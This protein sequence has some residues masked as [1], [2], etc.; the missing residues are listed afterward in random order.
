MSR[1]SILHIV[2]LL[3]ITLSARAQETVT[4]LSGNHLLT[5]KTNL[6]PASVKGV[7][8]TLEL[9]F[10]DD[11]TNPGAYP[12][13]TLWSDKYVFI[14][15][16]F[17]VDQLT[18]GV[19][20]FDL[21]DHTGR[22][23]DDA[24]TW[25]FKA[26]MLTSRPINL[27][28][29]PTDNIWLSFLY[30]PG[31]L[32]DTP[33][34]GD[35]LTLQFYAPETGTWHPVWKREG[36]AV[37]PFKH[38][39]V[40]V[41]DGK[42]LKKGFRFRFTAY[43]SLTTG[44]SD[45]AMKTSGDNWHIDYVRL[46]KNRHEF[47]TLMHDVAFTLPVRSLLKNHEA[48]PLKHFRQIYLNEMGSAISINYRNNDNIVRNVT[49]QFEIRN[50]STSAIVHTFSGGAT[51]TPPGDIV[52]YNAPL[53]YTF[54]LTGSDT[55][56]YQ[57]KSFLITDLF[58]Q[59]SNDTITYTQEFANY[60]SIDDGSAEAGYGITGQGSRNAMVAYR[61]RAFV[62]DSLRAVMICFNDSY[63][64]SNLRTFDIAVWDN[65]NGVPGNLIYL[66]EELMVEQ[67][68]GINGFH[69]YRLNDPVYV[70]NVFYVGWKQRS[71]TFLNAGIDLNTP[72]NGRQFYWLNGEWFQSQIEGSLM[73]RAVTGPK[74]PATGIGD[75]RAP[76]QSL[77]IW[78]N[79][80]REML[81]IEISNH[82]TG[83]ISYTITDLSG[84]VHLRT[85]NTATI[86][87]SALSPGVYLLLT[88]HNGVPA[89][90]NKFIKTY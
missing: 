33:E 54:S 28:L 77:K 30:Q 29:Q 53:F 78:P 2:I 41:T 88:T 26:D 19:A 57:I 62:A 15:N 61:Y 89:A 51:N 67:G 5:S 14:N 39:I 35:S 1:L 7:A 16:T 74:L 43:G 49:R 34:S 87:V 64:N 55:A 85:S 17:T 84:R 80:V 22:L 82:L 75:V 79:P 24:V 31:G 66:A 12:D 83:T 42:F 23:Y 37:H 10:F 65:N 69:T 68:D 4:G 90:R 58:D 32:G 52:T 73:I 3:L 36:S 25:G 38:V 71:E 11:F 81:N 40:P 8:D 76:L 63:L 48:M 13:S 44:T 21:L 46:G 47:D 86:D 59:K 70:D 6:Y 56:K 60:F 9:P 27:E 18:R 50:L 45:P 20:T 72:H